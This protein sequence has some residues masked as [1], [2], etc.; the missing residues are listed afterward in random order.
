MKILY[1]C[2]K[3]T[4][5]TKMCRV[6]FHGMSAIGKITDLVYSGIGWDNYDINKTVQDNIDILYGR[7]MPD[8][9]VAFKP[10]ELNNFRAI[11]PPK[12]L[13]YNEMWDGGGTRKEINNSG[14]DL[15]VCHHL[16]DMSKYQDLKGVKLVNI[17]H[18]AEASIYKDY[19]LAKTNDILLTGA[20]SRHYPFR[21]RLRSIIS[22][23]LSNRVKCKIL[24]HPGG[25]LNKAKSSVLEA[26]A[27]EINRSKITVTCSSRYKY[28][29]GKYVEIP[30]CGSL[31]AGDLPDE[32]HDFFKQF[33][34]VLDPSWSDQDIAHQLIKY[35]NKDDY[36][37]EK[38]QKGLELNKEYTQEKYAERFV[39]AVED[40]LRGR[41]G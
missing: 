19:G 29:L 28:R 25:D 11:K 6:R 8:I 36:R 7:E 2:N 17:S 26:Y 14:A 12:C 5:E 35:I 21:A 24:N 31:L 30:M 20:I 34:L 1:L 23:Y 41:N 39:K 3:H 13:R 15:L 27:K 33:M 32:D 40:F 9:V 38:I 37:N 4:F 22:N 10:L 16:N 18:C